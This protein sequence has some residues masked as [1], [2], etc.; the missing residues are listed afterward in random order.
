M[1]ASL[2]QSNQLAQS[3]V[4]EPPQSEEIGALIEENKE[5]GAAKGK[6]GERGMRKNGMPRKALKSL[7]QQEMERQSREI[8]QK[9]LADYKF[10][11][12]DQAEESSD[13]EPVVHENVSCDGCGMNP[14]IGVRYKC[15]VRKNFDLCAECEARLDHEYAFLKIKKPGNSPAFMVTVLNEDAPEGE[16]KL[17]EQ[18]AMPNFE[19]IFKQAFGEGMGPMGRGPFGGPRGPHGPHHHGPHGH[20]PH[21]HGPH[22]HGPHG[23]GPHGHGPHGGPGGRFKKM[24]GAFMEQMGMD[25]TQIDKA[26]EQFDQFKKDFKAQNAE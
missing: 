8:F 14:I 26:T 17:S 18:K 21:G 19:Q 7:I 23:H 15:S 16:E 2:M 1:A 3:I 24:M 10:S 22:G 25:Q 12:I 9:I 6:R 11:K 20:G 4:M 5:E 13:A